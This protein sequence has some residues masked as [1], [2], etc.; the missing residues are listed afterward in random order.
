MFK[1]FISKNR[2]FKI[3]LNAVVIQCLS[4]INFT[5]K[6][7]LWHYPY[8]HLNFK[9]LNQLNSKKIVNGMPLI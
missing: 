9:S 5:E 6:N 3:N 2:T 7:W 1:A 4:A 8:R